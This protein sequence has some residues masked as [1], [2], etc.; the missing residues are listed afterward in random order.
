MADLCAGMWPSG[1]QATGNSCMC[2]GYSARTFF[3][4]SL[5]SPLTARMTVWQND[6]IRFLKKFV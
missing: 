5:T 4:E 3:T 2:K 6:T 1:L